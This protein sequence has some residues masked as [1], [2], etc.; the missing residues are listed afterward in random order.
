[1]VQAQPQLPDLTRERAVLGQAIA[2]KERLAYVAEPPQFR[3]RAIDVVT[4]PSGREYA[5]IVNYARG[6]FTLIPKPPDWEQLRAPR[7]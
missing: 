4:T 7:R 6:E 5:R 3:G 2:S 1:M